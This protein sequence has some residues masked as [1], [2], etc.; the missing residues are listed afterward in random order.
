MTDYFDKLYL[1]S[2]LILVL[3]IIAAYYQFSKSIR[4]NKLEKLGFESML[5]SNEALKR[6][7]KIIAPSHMQN[8]DLPIGVIASNDGLLVF[9]STIYLINKYKITCWCFRKCE[10]NSSE[11]SENW[12]Q[13]IH[14]AN[15]NEDNKKQIRRIVYSCMSGFPEMINSDSGLLI[16]YPRPTISFSN[17]LQ[18]LQISI[19]YF[20]EVEQ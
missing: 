11:P 9:W 7:L 8:P 18:L 17:T 13:A 4:V 2:Y 5:G 15:I 1:L 10:S 20:K 6:R 12:F 19:N 3:I 16:V 14:F